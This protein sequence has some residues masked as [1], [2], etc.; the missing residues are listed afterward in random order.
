MDKIWDRK[1]FKVGGHCSLWRGRNKR[2]TT[3]N[4][5]KSTA[6]KKLNCIYFENVSMQET[7]VPKEQQKSTVYTISN[8]P[9]IF[10]NSIVDS[11]D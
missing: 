4:R 10:V 3:L 5:Q 7:E 8:T 1:S 11:T 6:K 9:T 2:I